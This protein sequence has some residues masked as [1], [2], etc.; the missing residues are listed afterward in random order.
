VGSGPVE[1]D[2]Q[3]GPGP[4]E[5]DLVA[6][7]GRVG[8]R[9]RKAA[10]DAEVVQQPLGVV[11]GRRRRRVV[12]GQRP[13]QLVARRAAGHPVQCRLDLVQVEP[14]VELRLVNGVGQASFADHLGE[15]DERAGDRRDGNPVEHGA[16]VGPQ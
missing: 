3:S 1:L 9:P 7:D 12:R 15:V 16:V 13:V 11:A 2:D 14:T 6:V 4:V 5:I 10:V 8:L